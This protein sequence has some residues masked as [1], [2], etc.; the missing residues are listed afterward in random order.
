MEQTLI[1][2]FAAPLKQRVRVGPAGSAD[3]ED[4]AVRMVSEGVPRH[5][6]QQG[7]RGEPI[8]REPLVDAGF[9]RALDRDRGRGT[10][11]DGNLV[12]QRSGSA[13]PRSLPLPARR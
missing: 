9:E 10:P 4:A 7:E 8:R 12:Q 2:R 6:D 1:G 11:G 13:Q 5:A 3:P